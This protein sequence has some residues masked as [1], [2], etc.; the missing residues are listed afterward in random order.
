MFHNLLLHVLFGDINGEITSAS[1]ISTQQYLTFYL[2][3]FALI[4]L[5]ATQP[6]NSFT[7]KPRDLVEA[8]VTSELNNGMVAKL[9]TYHKISLFS[10]VNSFSIWQGITILWK[11]I[12]KIILL[13]CSTFASLNPHTAINPDQNNFSK[14]CISLHIYSTIK[15]NCNSYINRMRCNFHKQ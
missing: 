1:W 7:H 12:L 9:K 3:Y 10:I 13:G 2:K 8:N 11:H 14:V 15:S 5:N 4:N 6:S